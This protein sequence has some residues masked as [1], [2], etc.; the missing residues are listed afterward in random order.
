MQVVELAGAPANNSCL[1]ALGG[2]EC[3]SSSWLG[4]KVSGFPLLIALCFI[5]FGSGFQLL[6]ALGCSCLVAVFSF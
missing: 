2:F 1:C 4:R 6:N 5:L 3:N